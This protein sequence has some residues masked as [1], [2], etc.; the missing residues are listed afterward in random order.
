MA[1][2]SSVSTSFTE[3]IDN[4]I[5][6]LERLGANVEG[7]S[8]MSIYE[9]AKILADQVKRNAEALPTDEEWGT[10]Q[11]KKK[12]PTTEE[13]E[14]IVQGIG[15]TTMK[16]E[17]E[18]INA[19]VGYSD[20]GYNEKGKAIQMIAR[21]VNSGTSFMKRNPFFANAVRQAKERAQ[22]KMVETAE[23]EYEK[24]INGR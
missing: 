17:G 10:E 6:T 1:R 11:R 14:Q 23:K 4:Y 8:K 9:G 7:I 13:K 16:K 15:I 18:H 5:Q 22:E 12:G 19:K 3:E 2:R 24:I 21:S 20:A